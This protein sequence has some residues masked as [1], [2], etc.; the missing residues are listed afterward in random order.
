[1][2]VHIFGPCNSGKTALRNA[3]K[4]RHPDYN[5]WC[6][7]DF[8]K[9]YG[10]GTMSGELDAQEE[11]I[12]AVMVTPSAF[13]ECSGTGRCASVSVQR[14]RNDQ[15]IV[16]LDTPADVCISRMRPGKY[17]GIPFPFENSDEDIIRGIRKGLDSGVFD[18]L[19]KK[20]P[21]LRLSDDL[22]MHE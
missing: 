11:F 3:L 12:R 17:D 4:E 7:D 21:I 19:H 6:I 18:I 14:R 20:V 16:I 2:I 1:M 5:S 13:S 15:C 8:R 10:D 9:A 22:S